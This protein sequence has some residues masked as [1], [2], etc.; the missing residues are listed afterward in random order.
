MDQ[1]ALT[2]HRRTQFY[3]IKDERWSGTLHLQHFV[4]FNREIYNSFMNAYLLFI[5]L[6]SVFPMKTLHTYRKKNLPNYINIC[7]ISDYT[8]RRTPKD[9]QNEIFQG[10][11]FK[12][13]QINRRPKRYA[14]VTKTLFS[15]HSLHLFDFE[16][17]S[18][19]SMEDDRQ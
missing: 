15:L 5:F 17:Y 14:K 9:Q 7:N 2:S 11:Y 8:L 6:C 3:R 13:I 4:E 18:V 12:T 1:I 19:L 10:F 16:M